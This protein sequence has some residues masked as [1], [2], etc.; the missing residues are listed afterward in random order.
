MKDSDFFKELERLSSLKGQNTRKEEEQ[1]ATKDDIELANLREDLEGKRQDRRSVE[2]LL[3][4]FLYLCAC[5]S[6][7]YSAL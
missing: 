5:I 1:I 2:T 3:V 6:Q 7:W 4:A